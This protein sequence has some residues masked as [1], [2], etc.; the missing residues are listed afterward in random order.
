MYAKEKEDIK[1]SLERGRR[2]ETVEVNVLPETNIE[3]E[4]TK[5]SCRDGRETGSHK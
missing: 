3:K 5:G 4:S 2:Q 1:R